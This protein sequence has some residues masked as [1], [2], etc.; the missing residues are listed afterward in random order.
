MK[1]ILTDIQD[2]TFTKR[3]VANVEGG[4]KELEDLRASYSNH[5]IEDGVAVP[6]DE[7]G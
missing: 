6:P 2:G 5:Q 1:D 7:L 4:N 3:L